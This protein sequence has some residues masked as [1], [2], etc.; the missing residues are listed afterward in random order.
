MS[1]LPEGLTR[2]DVADHLRDEDDI[3]AYLNAAT[4]DGSAALAMAL[5]DVV[6]VRNLS[7]L[8]KNTGLTRA[9]IRKALSGEGNPAFDTIHKIVTDLG[10]NIR[11]VSAGADKRPRAKAAAAKVQPKPAQSRPAANH[12]KAG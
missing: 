8:A 12:L 5:R 11:F 7:K 9:G 1:K 10:L 2:F 6:R 3:A 4:E